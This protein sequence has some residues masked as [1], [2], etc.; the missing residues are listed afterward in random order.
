MEFLNDELE[1]MV[2]NLASYRG[3][4][5]GSEIPLEHISG[6]PITPA[7]ARPAQKKKAGS[8]KDPAREYLIVLEGPLNTAEQIKDAASLSTAPAIIKGTGHGGNASFCRISQASKDRIESHLI[9]ADIPNNAW[10]HMIEISQAAKDLCQDTPYP[11]LGLDPTLPQN[12]PGQH[13]TLYYPRQDQYPVWYFFYGT[14]A[15]PDRLVGLLGLEESPVLKSASVTGGT[16]KTWQGKYKTVVD[17]PGKIQGWAYQ[18]QTKD[19]EDALRRYET[20]HY[21]VVRCKIDID[22]LGDNGVCGCTFRFV[23]E[24]ALD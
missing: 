4:E 11:T 5:C 21:E 20:A 6:A 23:D 18:V 10:P 16:V 3:T 2:S 17:G 13:Q 12:R 7:P 8:N 9:Q 24:S 22:I 15:E 1:R 19:H 14:L